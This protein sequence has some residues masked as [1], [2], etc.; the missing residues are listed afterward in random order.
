[1]DLDEF[2]T[3]LERAAIDERFERKLAAAK[4]QLFIWMVA[5]SALAVII[6]LLL[7]RAIWHLPP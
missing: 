5:L 4:R 6:S 7:A 2:K 1:M 3:Q